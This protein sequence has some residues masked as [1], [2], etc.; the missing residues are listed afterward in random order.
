MTPGG[1]STSTWRRLC[2]RWPLARRYRLAFMVAGVHPTRLCRPS[3]PEPR[4]AAARMERPGARPHRARSLNG[5]W[6]ISPWPGV[7]L[8]GVMRPSGALL[9]RVRVHPSRG[10]VWPR[11]REPS[12]FSLVVHVPLVGENRLILPPP[13]PSLPPAH[14]GHCARA[15]AMTSPDRPDAV[16]GTT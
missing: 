7:A 13:R 10:F 11:Q 15:A 6:G 9:S 8:C 2:R 5:D 3:P 12:V 4:P 1:S 16:A 14:P